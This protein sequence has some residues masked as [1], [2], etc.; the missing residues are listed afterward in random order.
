MTVLVIAQ[1]IGTV[2]VGVAPSIG[3]LL[4]GE[5][6]D[7]E[8]WAGLAR[9][10]STLGA[11]LLGLPLGNLAARRGRRV[12]LSGGWWM[13][14]AGAA[15]LVAAAQ[16]SMV[17][18][19]FVGLLLIGAGSAVSL[20]SRFAATDLAEPRHKAR[21]LALVV[22]VGT[23]GSV[24]GPNLGVPGELVGAATGLTIFASAF[25]IAAICLALAGLVVFVWLRPDPLLLLEQSAQTPRS[26]PAGKHPGRIRQVLVELRTNRRARVAMIAIL[27]AQ[28]VM[29]SIMT[30]TPVHVAHQGGSISII[31]ITISLHIAGMYGLSPLVGLIADRR[32]HRFT[33]STGIVIFLASLVIGAAKPDDTAWIIVSLILLGVGW[34]FVNVAGSALFSTAV[35]TQTRAA[36]QGGVDALS[37]LCGA[38]AAFAAGP[39]LTL[40]SFSALSILAIITL[41]PLTVLMATRALV[42]KAS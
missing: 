1:I 23:L 5:V 42:P 30:M 6:T 21:S 33:I 27:T 13:A 20:Q 38:T 29:V 11:A 24:L 25:L 8:A 15:L 37:N 3:V 34:S 4:A 19:L 12:A 39:L 17:V 7:S 10:A 32:G 18:P 9:T 36:S 16:G 40:T 41:I 31:G 14:A 35:P 2:G 28:V 26:A 22:W